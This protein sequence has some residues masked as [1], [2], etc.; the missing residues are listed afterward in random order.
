MG[1][2]C[3]CAAALSVLAIAINPSV[4]KL[5]ATPHKLMYPGVGYKVYAN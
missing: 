1:N 4:Q 5:H 3:W 2:F